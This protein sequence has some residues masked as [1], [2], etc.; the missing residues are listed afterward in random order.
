MAHSNL[1]QAL[2][3][4]LDI[5]RVLAEAPD[6]MRLQEL[7]DA[8][9]LKKTT[10]HNLITTL[11]ARGFVEKSKEN[12]FFIGPAVMELSSK[13]QKKD[14]LKKAASLLLNFQKRFPEITVTLSEM[15]VNAIICRLRL[16]PDRF[17]EL[18][19]PISQYFQPYISATSICLQATANNA[20]K[21]EKQYPFEE[22]GLNKW[23]NWDEFNTAKELVR[24]TGYYLQ[25]NETQ[26]CHTLAFA[27]PENYCLGI[28]VDNAE[29]TTIDEIISAGKEFQKNILEA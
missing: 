24:K 23:V 14:L 13:I 3:R 4:G 5:L 1:V 22:F 21:L 25:Y 27:V 28:R 15:T 2:V 20:E 11:R 10:A 18:Q 12:K 17:G 6:G 9:A 8:V 7:A 16:S 19:Q 26:N 29:K